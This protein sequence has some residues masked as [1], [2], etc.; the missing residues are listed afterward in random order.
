MVFCTEI[1]RFAGQECVKGGDNNVCPP[2]NAHRHTFEMCLHLTE[3]LAFSF[4][5]L[6]LLAR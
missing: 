6:L 4:F 3:A 2:E 1:K 5:L